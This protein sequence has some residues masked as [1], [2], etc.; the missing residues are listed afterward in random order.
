MRG[1]L[2]SAPNRSSTAAMVTTS[3]GPSAGATNMYD[4][5]ATAA[6]C[7][8][9]AIASKYSGE[10]SM[11]A[12]AAA[13]ESRSLEYAL[14]VRRAPASRGEHGRADDP[15]EQRE[16]DETPPSLPE[17]LRDEEPHGVRTVAHA[18]NLRASEQGR[19]GATPIPAEVLARMSRSEGR[20]GPGSG[21]ARYVRRVPRLRG[22]FRCEVPGRGSACCRATR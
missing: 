18:I 13:I 20:S 9:A 15:D 17:F 1:R 21:G 10:T 16:H 12:S 2:T 7:G 3:S 5:G 22:H 4:D 11:E 14:S 8:S 6:T 19:Q